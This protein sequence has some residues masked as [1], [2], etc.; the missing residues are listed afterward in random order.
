LIYGLG[1]DAIF[2]IDP[3]NRQARVIARHPSIEDAFGMMVTKDGIMYYG[4]KAHL[5][6]VDLR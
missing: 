3:E 4:S 1:D 6:R 2:V 5:W